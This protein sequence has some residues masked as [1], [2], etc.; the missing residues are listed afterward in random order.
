MDLK[1]IIRI[2]NDRDGYAKLFT[3]AYDLLL[4]KGKIE[5]NSAGRLTSLEEFFAYIQEIIEYDR[6]YLIRLPIDEPTLTIDAN[7]RTIDTSVFTKTNT[8]Q[9][10]QIA[11]ILVFSIDRY[12]DYKDLADNNVQIWVQW[13]APDGKGGF[14]EGAT[15]I[16]LTDTE[17][18]KGKLRFG[19]PIDNEITEYPGTVQFAVR[20]FMKDDVLDH[21][22]A[23]NE[24][25]VNKIVYSLN[26]LPATLTIKSAL[27]PE[28]NDDVAVNRPEEFFRYA[29]RNSIYTGEDVVIPQVPTFE[30]P[31]SQLPMTA[32]LKDNTLTLMAQAVTGDSGSIRYEWFYQGV[33]ETF[34]KNCREENWGTIGTAYCISKVDRRIISDDYYNN[35]QV[36]ATTAKDVYY[37]HVDAD[38]NTVNAFKVYT[39]EVE[40]KTSSDGTS[41]LVDKNGLPL[42]EK[43][44]TL[45]VPVEG[46]VTGIYTVKAYNTT[47][48]K[49]KSYESA[50]RESR[51]CVLVSPTEV[52]I[53]EDLNEKAF[54]LYEKEEGKEELVKV[55]AEI[56]VILATKPEDN[57]VFNYA[58]YKADFREEESPQ[59][60]QK[61]EINKY[62]VTE[63][64][65]YKAVITADLNRQ[66]NTG[67]SKWCKVTEMP[68]APDLTITTPVDTTTS[69]KDNE[70]TINK[71]LGEVVTLSL[72]AIVEKPTGYE[73]KLGDAANTIEDLYSEGLSYSWTVQ[74][75]PDAQPRA[76]TL[77]DIVDGDIEGNSISVNVLGDIGIFKPY[78]YTCTVFNHLNEKTASSEVIFQVG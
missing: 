58:W 19:W 51:Q 53:I 43:Y 39:D 24:I 35:S 28:L 14:R 67:T 23:G 4:E 2:D 56:K 37:S 13:T 70:M 63:P 52:N 76:V 1:M 15:Y 74:P 5:E 54:I 8:V 49:G 17:T 71:D 7:K 48:I 12:Y 34:A 46:N 72:S 11:E 42:Y 9:S 6:R 69:I 20:F 73:A 26:T 64:G 55:P 31:G 45:T 75:G 29:V 33:N 78:V 62:D 47:T 22:S 61:E 40:Y 59:L 65:W 38:K 25:T 66:T 36:D 32:T 18:E 30:A 21:D 50:P 68:K 77:E 3:Q 16:S 44:T 27:Q 41:M 60:L 10:D 57:T